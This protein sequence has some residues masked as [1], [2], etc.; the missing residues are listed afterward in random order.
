VYNLTSFHP[1][2]KIKHLVNEIILRLSSIG[3]KNI[4]TLNISALGLSNT[5]YIP[6]SKY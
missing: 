6:V 5:L 2:A 4:S 1:A 3:L